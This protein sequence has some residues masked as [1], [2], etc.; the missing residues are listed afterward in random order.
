MDYLTLA[1]IATLYF[2]MGVGFD[3]VESQDST[4][5][6]GVTLCNIFLWPAILLALG[7]LVAWGRKG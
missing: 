1:A 4:Q 2:F 3:I 6:A 7:L 5:S